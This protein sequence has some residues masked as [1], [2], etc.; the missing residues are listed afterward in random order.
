MTEIIKSINTGRDTDLTYKDVYSWLDNIYGFRNSEQVTSTTLD[1]LA[2][3]INAHKI[4]Y[5]ESKTFCEQKLNALMIPAIIISA[6][7]GLLGFIFKKSNY[8][9]IIIATCSAF[10]SLLLALISYL[11]LDAKAEAHK[12]SAYK[13]DKLQSLCE[14][15]SG[16][17]LLKNDADS[18]IKFIDDLELQVNEIKETNQFIIP[19]YIR[20]NY[21]YISTTNVFSVVKGLKYEEDLT[22]NK[23][24]NMINIVSA[25]KEYYNNLVKEK[26]AS[27]GENESLRK[28]ID[29]EYLNLNGHITDQN[30]ALDEVLNFGLKY[31]KIDKE[32]KEEIHNNIVKSNRNWTF[33]GWMKS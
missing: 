19:E 27:N 29:D 28:K 11:K 9:P 21:P 26:E 17:S 13:F 30:K 4:L 16:K 15:K 5:I 20:Y 24:K 2:I 7:T 33:F 14:F 22:I 1:I 31:L 8:G 23:L 18:I 6:V 32:I 3:Y 10:N 25:K 12:T